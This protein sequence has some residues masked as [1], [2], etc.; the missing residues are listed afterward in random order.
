MIHHLLEEWVR[1]AR[2]TL[3]IDLH[4]FIEKYREL[5]L[6]YLTI[7]IGASSIPQGIQQTLWNRWL[8]PSHLSPRRA[9]R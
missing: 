2:S 3:I 6:S 9:V 5:T 7:F 1:E 4:I 8:I